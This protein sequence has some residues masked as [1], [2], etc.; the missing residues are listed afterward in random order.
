MIFH[1]D[2]TVFADVAQRAAD[3][4]FLRVPLLGGTVAD[5]DDIFVLAQ[6]LLTLGVAVPAVTEMLSDVETLV[7]LGYRVNGSSS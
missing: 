3:G 4:N 2:I 5:E 6:E 1:L 7:W